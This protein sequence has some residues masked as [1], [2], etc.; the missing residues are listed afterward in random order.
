M[1]GI[2]S[3]ILIRIYGRRKGC[4]VTPGDFIDLGGRQAVDLALHRLAKTGT[5]RRLTRGLYDYPRIDS[6]L[7]PLHPSGTR[8]QGSEERDL[9]PRQPLLKT[10][11]VQ[12]A[13]GELGEPAVGGRQR[14]RN[15]DVK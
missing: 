6:D 2:D 8:G 5:L 14:T 4:V 7:G 10:L 15:I 3:N 1:Q 11:P 9:I 12:E 13:D